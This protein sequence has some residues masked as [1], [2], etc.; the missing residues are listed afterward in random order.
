MFEQSERVAPG[1]LRP[2]LVTLIENEAGAGASGRITMKT[3]HLVDVE[4]IE[5][6]PESYGYTATRH[7]REVGTSYFDA[8]AMAISG[9]QS[10]T[11]AMA[12]STCA[13]PTSQARRSQRSPS[14]NSPIQIAMPP[15]APSAGA[16]IGRSS[17]P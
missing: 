14:S 13:E 3:N 2:R 11:T 15:T 9:G 16:S 17:K 12:G 10:S 7:Q 1:S 6:I 5:V 8:V 4:I